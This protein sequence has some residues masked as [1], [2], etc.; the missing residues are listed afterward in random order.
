MCAE[1]FIVQHVMSCKKGGFVTL[2]HNEVRD[3][4]ATLLS[5]IHKDLELE[6]SRLTLNRE[7]QT[8]RS[9]ANTDDEARLD[10]CARSF[11][12]SGQK[13]F[14]DVRVFDANAQSYS[15]KTLKQ[16]YSFNENEKKRNYNTKIME[17]YQGSF[18]PLIFTVVEGMG[19][20][21]RAFYS[22]LATCCR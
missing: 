14:F 9:T 15:K 10:I 1:G 13:A 18:T 6:L 4:T 20:E 8:M 11:W 17:V 21:G 7:E 5:D 3:I 12:V 2:R 16:C 19:D 22:R